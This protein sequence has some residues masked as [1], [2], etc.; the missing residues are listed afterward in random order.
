MFM[1][2]TSDLF[3]I[4]LKSS[5]HNES[6]VTDDPFRDPEESKPAASALF[7]ENKYPQVSHQSG[8]RSEGLSRLL[9]PS[10]SIA[11]VEKTF[12][13]PS[14]RPFAPGGQGVGA[15]DDQGRK[16]FFWAHLCFQDSGFLREAVIGPE[17]NSV[18]EALSG[19]L[20][21]MISLV[22]RA[23]AEALQATP[24]EDLVKVSSAHVSGHVN[25]TMFNLA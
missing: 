10:R 18:S 15:A 21:L 25:M 4:I 1:I 16:M 23:G 2:P 24:S 19:L 11:A 14:C 5:E 20:V 8:G 12:S 17:A 7:S 9:K 13:G 3:Y 22:T 6:K